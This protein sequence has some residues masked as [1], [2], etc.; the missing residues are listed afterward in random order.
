MPSLTLAVA[1]R[2]AAQPPRAGSAG[3][4]GA[5]LRLGLGAFGLLGPAL[6]VGKPRAQLLLSALMWARV[7]CGTVG[8]RERA[9]SATGED[10]SEPSA[11]TTN[12][13]AGNVSGPV[14]Q[15]GHIGGGLHFYAPATPEPKS[16]SRWAISSKGV[17]W[18]TSVA[19]LAV[20]GAMIAFYASVDSANHQSDNAK[21]AST[22]LQA[23]VQTTQGGPEQ[24]GAWWFP[25][26]QLLPFDSK[27]TEE[28]VAQLFTG[29]QKPVDTYQTVIKLTL[30]GDRSHTVSINEMDAKI[31]SRKTPPDAGG[32]AVLSPG[33]GSNDSVQI[34]FDLDERV[35]RA[36]RFVDGFWFAAHFFDGHTVTVAHGEVTT[37]EIIVKTGTADVSYDLVLHLVVDGKPVDQVVKN[38]S[39]PFRTRAIAASYD[40]VIARDQNVRWGVTKGEVP[41]IAAG[42]LCSSSC[43]QPVRPIASVRPSTPR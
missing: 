39:Q 2:V 22:P 42:W 16:R 6:G 1:G 12:D 14:V 30:E 11:R 40:Q 29:S 41:A 37:F 20:I 32:T 15:A 38:G 33:Q 21:A 9:M 10:K 19:V 43:R 25:A 36:R 18:T 28:Q 27:P 34:G 3:L 23:T 8:R 7:D 24:I 31:V 5:G 35:P 13:I 4:L 26:K 17:I